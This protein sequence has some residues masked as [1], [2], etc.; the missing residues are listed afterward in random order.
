MIDDAPNLPA[1]PD[2]AAVDGPIYQ[3]EFTDDEPAAPPPGAARTGTLTLSPGAQGLLR[4]GVHVF[5]IS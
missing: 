3:G 1:V 4:H 5:G 2:D